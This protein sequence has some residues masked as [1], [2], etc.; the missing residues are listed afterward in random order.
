MGTMGI[1]SAAAADFTMKSRTNTWLRSRVCC[2]WYPGPLLQIP[3]SLQNQYPKELVV[4]SAKGRV[5]LSGAQGKAITEA[6]A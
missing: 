4:N 1:L 6:K 2:V 5:L 3:C